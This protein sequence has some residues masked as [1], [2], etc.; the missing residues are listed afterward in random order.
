MTTNSKSRKNHLSD[1][2]IDHLVESQADDDA[3]WDAPIEVSRKL[4][5]SLSLPANLA[6]KAAFLAKLHK[7]PDMTEWLRRIITEQIELEESAFM[8]FKRILA[9][10]P[11][12]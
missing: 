7:E 3:A 4:P 10:T 6:M 9:S 11:R 8:E 1:E 5:A 2:E 12:A